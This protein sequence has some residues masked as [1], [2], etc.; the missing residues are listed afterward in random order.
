MANNGSSRVILVG[1]SGA[2]NRLPH[3]CLLA[4]WSTMNDID[5]S[6]FDGV[7][8]EL[9][10]LPPL[11]GQE[12]KFIISD[13]NNIIADV[14]V[15]N[16]TE[17]LWWYTRTSSRDRYFSSVLDDMELLARFKNAFRIGVPNNLVI[18]C[19]DPYLAKA[20]V[21]LAA[22]F[23]VKS[24]YTIGDRWFWGKRR[25]RLQAAPWV[26]GIKSCLRGLAHKRYARSNRLE[27]NPDRN[28]SHNELTI[29]F[30]WLKSKNLSDSELPSDTFFGPLP[31]YLK[32]LGHEV[33]MFGDLLD[34]PGTS[35]RN[36]L[37]GQ[38]PPVFFPGD[39]HTY[40]SI[41]MAYLVG[42]FCGISIPKDLANTHQD[43]VPLIRR[44]IHRNRSNVI[45]CLALEGTLRRLCETV[46]PVRIIH[47]GENFPWERTCVR[48]ARTTIPD[49]KIIGF[50]HCAPLLAH[51]QIMTTEKEKS[52][53][54]DPQKLVC[55]GPIARKIMIRYGGHSPEDVVSGC[56][57]RHQYLWDLSE[58]SRKRRDIRTI[59]VALEGIP[60][61]PGLVRFVWEAL[62][63]SPD[64]RVVLRPHPI[65][66]KD[67]VLSNAR[68][69][70]SD[71][72]ALEFSNNSDIA[73]D[74]EETD[75]LIYRGSTVAIE[76]GYLGIPLI[77]IDF[78][79]LLYD[80]PLFEIDNLK[81]VVRNPQELVEAV[82]KFNTM[83]EEEYLRERDALRL[84]IDGYFQKPS[85]SNIQ[86][87]LNE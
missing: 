65:D 45:H 15:D 70:L 50:M 3:G 59:L 52:V 56:A 2:S 17:G 53:R 69:C 61:I 43:L 26:N 49:L 64:F 23:G 19:P 12:K 29:I 28:H 73:V 40:K 75:L 27:W 74:L 81:E 80:D 84:Y 76:A 18:L 87:F 82:T 60:N 68:M 58:R 48:V 22:S 71:L 46:K 57:L 14:G 24:S 35:P 4:M 34:L 37:V 79:A 5:L 41:A 66:T 42:M 21:K 16:G 83:D 77:H 30:S 36:S 11:T 9:W 38:S 39:F 8:S 10:D 1:S 44:D 25:I 33:V 67:R 62:D 63:N 54:P 20:L 85:E 47:S 51:L 6:G 72:H 13:F 31:G 86:V 32:N 78:Q 55:T 7:I